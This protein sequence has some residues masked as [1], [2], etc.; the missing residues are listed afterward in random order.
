MTAQYSWQQMNRGDRLVELIYDS[1]HFG[2]PEKR[3]RHLKEIEIAL[4]SRI[5]PLFSTR[6]GIV[7]APKNQSVI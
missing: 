7:E 2:D 6:E 3:T 1:L 4:S 5:G